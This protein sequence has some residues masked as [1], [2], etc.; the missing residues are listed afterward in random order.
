M[1]RAI[2][3]LPNHD[4]RP[5]AIREFGAPGRD[6]LHRRPWF[7]QQLPTAGLKPSTPKSE[8]MKTKTLAI[9]SAL[10]GALAHARANG[11]GDSQS[12]TER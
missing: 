2:R 1:W 11:L 7:A 9:L 6:P 8:T 12:D 5:A 4:A 3:A 10:L